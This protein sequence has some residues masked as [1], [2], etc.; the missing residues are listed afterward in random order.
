MVGKL[1]LV[2]TAVAAL[3]FTWMALRLRGQRRLYR[4]W[5]AIAN[6]V[7]LMLLPVVAVPRFLQAFIE[8][9]NEAA[10]YVANL[11][12]S[13]ALPFYLGFVAM[14]IWVNRFFFWRDDDGSSI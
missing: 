14:H 8:S 11:V 3:L 4:K 9:S 1:F 10:L 5:L 7:L 12:E 13:V 2:S 6:H